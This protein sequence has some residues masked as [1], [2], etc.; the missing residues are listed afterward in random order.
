MTILCPSEKY[1]SLIGTY[2]DLCLRHFTCYNITLVRRH[3]PE[4]LIF[5]SALFELLFS[6]KI[7]GNIQ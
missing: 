1:Q 2:M 7:D 5:F 3:I 6:D 4:P